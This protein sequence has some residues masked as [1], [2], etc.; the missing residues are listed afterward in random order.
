[1]KQCL[2]WNNGK[3]YVQSYRPLSDLRHT[4]LATVSRQTLFHFHLPFFVP[5]TIKKD[6]DRP[7]PVWRH[8]HL[9]NWPINQS[10]HQPPYNSEWMTI[11]GVSIQ[12]L[13]FGIFHLVFLLLFFLSRILSAIYK[14]CRR[15][16]YL[17]SSGFSRRLGDL[18]FLRIIFLFFFLRTLTRTRNGTMPCERLEFCHQ[19][20]I[21]AKMSRN[22][23]PFLR[24]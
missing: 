18:R 12:T 2:A 1:M 3:P 23:S 13:I 8:T 21:R 22:R 7:L 20:R 24:P 11:N 10:I 9:A 16:R 17:F 4:L 15:C 14:I 5:C 19:S 6:Q